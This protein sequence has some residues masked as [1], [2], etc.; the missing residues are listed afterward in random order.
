MVRR[1][2]RGRVGLLWAASALAAIATAASVSGQ[3]SRLGPFDGH[4]D[5]G[6]PKI[7]GSATYNAVSQEFALAAGGVEHVGRSATS[8][9]SSGSA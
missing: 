2:L 3:G 1:Q 9:A 8:S 5:V 6:S 4:G 7:A